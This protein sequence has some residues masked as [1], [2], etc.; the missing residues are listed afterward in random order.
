MIEDSQWW[1]D[2]RQPTAGDKAS[3]DMRTLV[4]DMRTLVVIECKG[5]ILNILN[6]DFVKSRVV[7]S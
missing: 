5:L 1:P 7:R 4:T 3:T 2:D 6:D